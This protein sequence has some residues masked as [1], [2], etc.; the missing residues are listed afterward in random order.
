MNQNHTKTAERPVD[1]DAVRRAYSPKSNTNEISENFDYDRE[2][3]VEYSSAHILN[4]DPLSLVSWLVSAFHGIEK[5]LTM[6]TGKEGF[7]ARKIRPM[8]AA[9]RKLE[10]E[11]HAGYATEGARGSL[12]AYVRFN[13]DLGMRIPTEYER[14]VR[15]F[16]DET[17]GQN[18]LGGAIAWTRKDIEAATDFDY[19]AFT[20]TRCSL[21]QFTGE[22][23][24]PSELEKA[25][26]QALKSPRSCN[27]E[28]RRVHVVYDEDL[29]NEVLTYHSGNRGFGHKL[30]ALLIITADIRELDMVGERNQ[31]WIDGGIF[32]M[33]LVMALH[34]NRLGSC[35]LNWSVDHQQDKR[36]RQA[37]DI[38]DHE[39][40]ITFLGIGQMP[41]SFEVCASPSPNVADVMS[42]LQRR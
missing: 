36:L 29:R 1:L 31:G 8:I 32:A 11:G 5:G 7:G 23:V 33:S 39:A 25:V 27:R 4:Q 15:A 2:R 22:P 9:I 42:V 13:D 30:G 24:A 41:E 16:V 37:F 19:D 38:P 12:R 21:R 18:L 26:R 35:M 28:M 10:S 6:G 3:F 14:D 34:A 20:Q 17:A 40:I